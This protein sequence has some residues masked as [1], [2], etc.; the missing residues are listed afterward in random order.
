MWNRQRKRDIL[1]YF[2]IVKYH[3]VLEQTP[4][5]IN[6]T[7]VFQ[8]FRKIFGLKKKVHAKKIP[9]RLIDAIHSSNESETNTK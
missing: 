7:R 3:T 5:Y 8:W 4:A 2:D 1:K 9:Q 6:T